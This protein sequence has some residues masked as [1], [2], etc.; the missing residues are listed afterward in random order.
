MESMEKGYKSCK[1]IKNKLNIEF[2]N[3]KIIY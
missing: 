3:Y 1:D 2:V